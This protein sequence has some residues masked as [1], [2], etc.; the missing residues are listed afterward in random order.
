MVGHRRYPCKN[1][2]KKWYWNQLK[3]KEEK[4]NQTKYILFFSNLED[5][6]IFK[7]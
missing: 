3:T 1:L 2:H 5:E 6:I 4:T 7:G